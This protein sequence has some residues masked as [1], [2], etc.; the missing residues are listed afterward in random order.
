MSDNDDIWAGE[1]MAIDWIAGRSEMTEDLSAI[2]ATMPKELDGAAV[3]FLRTVGNAARAA[4]QRA[5]QAPRDGAPATA[6]QAQAAAAPPAPSP[7][8]WEELRR[9][10]REHRLRERL[11]ELWR[12][13][14]A[15]PIGHAPRDSDRGWR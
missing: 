15:I 13:N 3:G 14:S 5:E 8:D 9:R 11:D 6:P 7:I 1:G 4:A 10:Q 2:V 12:A